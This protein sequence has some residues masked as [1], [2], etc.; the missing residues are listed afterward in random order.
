[1]QCI[2]A[3]V[4]HPNGGVPLAQGMRITFAMHDLRMTVQYDA[5]I[6]RHVSI[7]CDQL[8]G[9]SAS[10]TP[11]QAIFHSSAMA[12]RETDAVF[13]NI[14]SMSSAFDSCTT[15]GDVRK[16]AQFSAVS[17]HLGAIAA[18]VAAKKE[19]LDPE[20]LSNQL[21]RRVID[22]CTGIGPATNQ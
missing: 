18:L 19:L 10:L 4:S 11:G 22:A 3:K 13:F 5:D 1:M 8:A 16:S 17:M 7:I 12:I 20:S 15:P 6:K 21:R 14:D 9:I 2:Q